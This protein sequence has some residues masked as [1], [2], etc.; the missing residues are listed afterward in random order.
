MNPEL[1]GEIERISIEVLERFALVFADPAPW[2]ED[3]QAEE[4]LCATV[5]FH[6]DA[7]GTLTILTS[8]EAASELAASALGMDEEAA[9]AAAPDTL[10]ELANQICGQMITAVAGD[11]AA[12]E[13]GIPDCEGKDAAMWPSLAERSGAVCFL[14]DGMSPMIVQLDYTAAPAGVEA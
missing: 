4:S 8:A 11:H 2:E 5:A 3:L 14:I 1:A 10:K 7:H 12:I 6:G 9:A 13:L